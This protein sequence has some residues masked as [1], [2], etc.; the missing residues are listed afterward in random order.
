MPK[1]PDGRCVKIHRSY[2]IGE[3]ARV[4]GVAKGTVFRWLK[5]GDLS[6]ITDQ[7]PNLILGSDLAGY[8]KA[9]R[10]PKQKCALIECYCV[11]CRAPRQPA[12]NM[13][14]VRPSPNGTANL[15]ALCST[16]G[17]WM[18]KRVSGAQLARLRAL[19]DLNNQ[20][21]ATTHSKVRPSLPE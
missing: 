9:R 13:A 3:A 15:S 2:T 8:L 5:S 19:L 16:C 6:A 17:G 11:T 4:I 10:K 14:D 18:H 12:G 7:R 1:R 20:A 21:S